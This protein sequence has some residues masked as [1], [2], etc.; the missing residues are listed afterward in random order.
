VAE[1]M[2]IYAEISGY[3]ML[4]TMAPASSSSSFS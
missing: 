2:A 1:V 4:E 3:F